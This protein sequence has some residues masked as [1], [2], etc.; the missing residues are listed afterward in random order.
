[1]ATL[2]IRNLPEEVREALALRA[3]IEHRSLA[4]Q[5]VVELSRMSEV[6]AGCRRRETIA[7]IKHDLENLT[8]AELLSPEDMVREDRNR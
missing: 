1:M 6:Q 4:Q 7:A 5:A 2:Q 8:M 3:E